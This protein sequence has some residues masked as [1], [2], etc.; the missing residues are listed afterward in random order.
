MAALFN[1]FDSYLFNKINDMIFINEL[2][3]ENKPGRFLEVNDVVCK[4]LG[5]SRKELLKLSPFE[6]TVDSPNEEI[7][8]T[9]KLILKQDKLVF[10]RKLLSKNKT[11]IPIEIN[12]YIF[13]IKRKKVIFCIAHDIADRKN[14]EQ[15]LKES[16]EKFRNLAEQSPNIIFINSMGRIVYANK[17]AESL[18][19]YTIVEFYAP[20]FDFMSLIAPEDINKIKDNFSRHIKGEDISPYEY[21]IVNK[22]S[23]RIKVIITT[24][25]INYESKPAILGIITDLTELKQKENKI[26]ES[27]ELYRLLIKTSPDAVTAS[28]L[29][30]KITYVS[31]RTLEL[32]GYDSET[33]LLGKSA[34]DLIAP[35]EQPRAL[36]NLKKTFT[37][38][39]EKNLEYTLL[40]KDGNTFIGELNAALV[41]D[42][43]G[44]P[45]GFIATT[46]D[47]TERKRIE[48][49][50][51]ESETKYRFLYEESSVINIIIGVDGTIKDVNKQVVE[52]LGYTKDQLIG[53]NTID[54]IV[55][56]HREKILKILERSFKNI[57]SPAIEV[58]IFAKDRSIHTI[59]FSQG[60]VLLYEKGEVVGVLFT[61]IDITERKKTDK[62]LEEMYKN[63][64]NSYHQ[65]QETQEQLIQAE[66]FATIGK[67]ASV[68]AHEV[69]NPLEAIKSRVQLL[70]E[71]LAE[72]KDTKKFVN[73]LTVVDEQINRVAEIVKNLLE[74]SRTNVKKPFASANI[75]NILKNIIELEKYN[76]KSANAELIY[77]PNLKIPDILADLDGMQQVFLNI[78]N[79]ALESMPKGG[80]LKI[81]TNISQ[82]LKNVII[83]FIDTGKGIDPEDI[84]KVFEPFY[85]TKEKGTGLGMAIS[86]NII[87]QH[88][89]NIKIDSQ[90]RKGT[91]A[92]I[93]LPLSNNLDE[94]EIK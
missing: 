73:D 54:F 5:Y 66:K 36:E 26:K 86:Q 8:R 55:S 22:N 6:I 30:G 94:T 48:K 71:E 85:S 63:L 62:Q 57:I 56:E 52:M 47:V 64:E 7:M 90:L 75:N 67:L 27:E 35:E 38:G 79:N 15:A 91:T 88:H 65:L 45:T 19:G 23:K 89:G 51:Q 43:N 24:K 68:V 11:V 60:Q 41:K 53:K 37:T 31:E 61:G 1:K 9:G 34:I 77:E 49:L 46:R 93:V 59:L 58:E 32:H 44:N 16:E 78:I 72:I 76:F 10:E 92:T 87:Q 2:D 40:K 25:L 80:I 12:A 14:T 50:L 33:E 74:F 83:S 20:G 84:D 82:D 29:E 13:R 21:T 69:N 17:Q 70:Q 3:A 18:M 81:V 4:K 39:L 28:N 42:N